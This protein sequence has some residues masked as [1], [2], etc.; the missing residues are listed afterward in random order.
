MSSATTRVGMSPAEIGLTSKELRRLDRFRTLVAFAADSQPSG[1]LLPQMQELGFDIIGP[2]PI[3]EGA[4]ELLRV[5]KPDAVALRIDDSDAAGLSIIQKIWH[6]FRVPV[7]VMTDA[8]EG[9]F[10]HDATVAGAFGV[11]HVDSDTLDVDA[12]FTAAVHRGS[13]LAQAIHRVDQLERN[14]ANRRVVEQAKWKLVQEKGIDEPEA[15]HYLQSVARN[16]RAPLVDV[17]QSVIDGKPLPKL[18]S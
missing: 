18:P 1:T 17:A 10:F 9:A 6:D 7:V 4:F 12:A 13:A 3:G 2:A 11:L 15:H 14:L 16:T 5:E 8:S